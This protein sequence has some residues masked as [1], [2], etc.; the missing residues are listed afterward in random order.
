MRPAQRKD[1]SINLLAYRKLY[2][3]AFTCQMS[4]A[5]NKLRL[6]TEDGEREKKTP[7]NTPEIEK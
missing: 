3:A 5:E 1:S 2:G 7:E 6:S 4:K